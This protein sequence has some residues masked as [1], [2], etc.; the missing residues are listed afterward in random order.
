MRRKRDNSGYSAS[1]YG[2][3]K[4][5]KSRKGLNIPRVREEDEFEYYTSE[6]ENGEVVKK[7][8]RKKS[9]RKSRSPR[10][11][12]KSPNRSKS[13]VRGRNKGVKAT[14]FE[15][16]QTETNKFNYTPTNPTIG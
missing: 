6:D 9:P 2:K 12:G 5:K 3:A 15:P 14:V 11:A 16:A 1:S 4:G 8:R 7:L 10:K 13:P